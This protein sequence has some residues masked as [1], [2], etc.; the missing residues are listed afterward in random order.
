MPG[1]STNPPTVRERIGPEPGPVEVPAEYRDWQMIEG[2]AGGP[3]V[4]T[5]QTAGG[6]ETALLFSPGASAETVAAKLVQHVPP[7]ARMVCTV[8]QP[9][10][11]GVLF[12]SARPRP[13]PPPGRPPVEAVRAAVQLL[14]EAADEAV[15]LDEHGL[16]VAHT[17]DAAGRDAA[18]LDVLARVVSA[19]LGGY[20]GGFRV[21]AVDRLGRPDG[22]Q[23]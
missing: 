3:F 21:V 4:L 22:A 9:E 12:T 14:A 18:G 23:A 6:T 2:R 15:V 19:N 11:S 13:M 1:V 20:A 8:Q 7:T 10:W 17:L 16:V 5:S